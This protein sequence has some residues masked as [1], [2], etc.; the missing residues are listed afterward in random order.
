MTS[1]AVPGGYK[2]GAY[3]YDGCSD[4]PSNGADK[5]IRLQFL[6]HQ[7]SGFWITNV[8]NTFIGNV[9]VGHHFGFWI[10]TRLENKNIYIFEK[11]VE[12]LILILI[13]L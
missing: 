8:N 2:S 9:A 12:I 5:G 7:P 13:F 3:L 4:G 11:K 10:V 1:R 6:D